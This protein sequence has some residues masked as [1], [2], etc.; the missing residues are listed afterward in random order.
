MK[1]AIS[2]KSFN[3]GGLVTLGAIKTNEDTLVAID[4]EGNA[5]LVDRSSLITMGEFMALEEAKHEQS[6]VFVPKGVMKA[7]VNSG[8]TGS[9]E[10]SKVTVGPKP[11]RSTKAPGL[12]LISIGP[13][14]DVDSIKAMFADSPKPA[15]PAPTDPEW[16]K[17]A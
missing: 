11:F 6:T 12:E 14:A 2:M 7:L 15:A 17:E 13:K 4:G 1:R 9:K 10:L 8:Y 5:T 16:A 3:L